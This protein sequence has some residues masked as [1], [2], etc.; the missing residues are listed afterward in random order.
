MRTISLLEIFTLLFAFCNRHAV[1]EYGW[2]H[3]DGCCVQANQTV[4]SIRNVFATIK[5]SKEPDRSWMCIAR[6][7]S[8]DTSSTHIWAGLL[9][10]TWF[11]LDPLYRLLR[12]LAKLQRFCSDFRVFQS[13]WRYFCLSRLVLLGNH[14]D[15]WTFGAVDP[16]SG[17]AAL[18]EV[19]DQIL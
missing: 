18:L 12:S 1:I 5:G 8:Y 15:A 9:M 16:N 3:R 10:L 11:F 19:L 4:T 14:R 13:C 2:F 7:L 17:T 6:I